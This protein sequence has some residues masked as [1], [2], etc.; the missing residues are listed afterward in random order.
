M[1]LINKEEFVRMVE[2]GTFVYLQADKEDV[3]NAIN[4][5][6][7]IIADRP[8]VIIDNKVCYI[9]QGHIDAMIKYEQDELLKL[10]LSRITDSM[11]EMK[12]LSLNDIRGGANG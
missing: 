10:T 1:I 3:V 2:D 9:T 4:D 7:E 11:N 5:M 8:L 6:P 12:D